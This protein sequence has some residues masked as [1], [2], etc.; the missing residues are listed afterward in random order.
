MDPQLKDRRKVVHYRGLVALATVVGLGAGLAA[1]GGNAPQAAPTPEGQVITGNAPW[2]S[3]SQASGS[4]TAAT[5]V[6]NI[7]IKD[8]TT[9]EGSEPAYIGSGGVGAASL[10][11]MKA[12]TSVQVVVDNKDAMPHTFTVPSLGFNQTIAPQAVTKFTLTAKTAGT[13][14]WYCAIPCGGWVMSHPGYMKGSFTV[15]TS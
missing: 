5:E 15:T 13:I 11:S 12:G 7:T 3:G 8:V 2:M 6:V 14:P 4:A 10:F 9:P 1:C